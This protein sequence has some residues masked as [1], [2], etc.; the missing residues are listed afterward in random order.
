MLRLLVVDDEP[1][2][3]WA[4][5][6]TLTGAG[7]TI[8][9]AEDGASAM[10]ALAQAPGPVD[11]VILDYRLPDSNDLSLLASIRLLSPQSAV[12]LMTAFGSQEI[13]RDAERLG[14]YH[15]ISKPF[16]MQDLEPL[17]LRACAALPRR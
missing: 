3:R 9:E 12:V 5:A 13:T 1:L 11:A 10:R 16:E 7:H 15:V 4:I 2:I 8:I 17:I 14:A 6:Q